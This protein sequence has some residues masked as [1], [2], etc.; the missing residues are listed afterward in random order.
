MTWSARSESSLAG[1]GLV[2][3]EARPPS[4]ESTADETKQDVL[5]VYVLDLHH[6]HLRM[7]A[8]ASGVHAETH[9]L[10]Q[11][12]GLRRRSMAALAH[13]LLNLGR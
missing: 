3:R 4:A 12:A 5:R 8:A 2:L 10:F 11:V 9:F 7:V 13:I 1:A 6:A